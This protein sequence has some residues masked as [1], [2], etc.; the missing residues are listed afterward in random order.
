MTQSTFKQLLYGADPSLRAYALNLTR[1]Q[2]AANDLYQET[3]LKAYKYRTKFRE[4]SNFNAW[5]I[6][7]MKNTFINDYRRRKRR[8]TIFDFTPDQYLLNSS[9]QLVRNEGE[10]SMTMDEL[11]DMIGEL[12][13]KLRVPFLLQYQGYRYDEISQQLEVPEGTIKS[14]IHFAR[15]RL[16]QTIKDSYSLTSL[17]EMVA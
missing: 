8:N 12:P 7:L 13:E 15:K 6:T 9:E 14:R 16:K 2:E 4:D 3:A 5:A 1:D 10:G 11:Q 17:S